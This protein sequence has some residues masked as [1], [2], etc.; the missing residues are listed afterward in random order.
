MK[1]ALIDRYGGNDVVKVADIAIPVMGPVDLLVQ[2]HA[3]GVNPVDVRTRDGQLKA[4]LKYR[5]PLVLGNDLSGVV[6][7]VGPRV[8]YRPSTTSTPDRTNWTLVADSLPTCSV[9]RVLSNVTICDTFATESF[10]RPVVRAASN[11]LPGASTQRRLLESGTQTTVAIRL[12]FRASPWMTTTGRRKPGPEPA[13]GGRSAHQ[14]SPWE[15]TTRCSPGHADLRW[16]RTRRARC[17]RRPTLDPSP[18]LPHPG[19]GERRTPQ[20]P[21]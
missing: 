21:R 10:E 17:R 12:R 20:A 15:I 11:A 4:L 9:R 13:G 19:H 6:A 2:V 18:P 1:A 3:A 7:D 14:T 8:G 5:F 16:Q